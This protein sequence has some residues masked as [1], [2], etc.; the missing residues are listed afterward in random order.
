MRALQQERPKLAD[1][2]QRFGSFVQEVENHDIEDKHDAGCSS[3][4]SDSEG[5]LNR[6]Q[7]QHPLS[8]K[9]R[10][11]EMVP[12]ERADS[13]SAGAAVALADGVSIFVDGIAGNELEPSISE[14]EGEG[15]QDC[16]MQDPY[17]ADV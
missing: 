7:K 2:R 13:V 6:R 1:L 17:M 4:S 9:R 5:Y 12:T 11:Q 10:R 14:S 16:A 15:L 8:R 3:E